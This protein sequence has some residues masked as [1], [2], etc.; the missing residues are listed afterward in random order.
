[1]EYQESRG[2]TTTPARSFTTTQNVNHS[3]SYRIRNH[4]SSE[5]E[6]ESKGT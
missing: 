2:N 5:G 4:K 3:F 6:E 1:M